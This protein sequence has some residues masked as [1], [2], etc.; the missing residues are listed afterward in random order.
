MTNKSL[1]QASLVIPTG[2]ENFIREEA[3]P[4]GSIK[5]AAGLTLTG[6]TAPTIAAT[7]TTGVAIVGAASTTALGT[8]LYPIP[9]DYDA[10][11]DY[12]RVK[13][14]AEVGGA[15][16]NALTLDAT[17]YRKRAG[18]AISADLDPTASAVI[19]A[20]ASPTD[21]AAIRELI[22][23]GK[24][25]QAGDCLTINLLTQA[26]TTDPVNIWGVWVERKSTLVP[27]ALA[28]RS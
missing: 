21:D 4:L 2:G 15:T 13:V 1:S 16:N 5:T 24:G 11:A 9:S 27:A 10:T 3:I 26:H 18:T 22:L 8:L 19:P 25:C 17:V 28:D 6:A 14:L 23:T 7:E 20:S 12:L